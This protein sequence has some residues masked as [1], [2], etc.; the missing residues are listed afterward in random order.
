MVYPK[1]IIDIATKNEY[2]KQF[3]NH[4]VFKD[5]QKKTFQQILA[6]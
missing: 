2:S 6:H 1:L 3:L 4:S 5:W